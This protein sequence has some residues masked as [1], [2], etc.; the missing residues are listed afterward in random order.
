MLLNHPNSES[1]MHSR[2]G[3]FCFLIKVWLIDFIKALTH[4][5]AVLTVSIN[6]FKT[7]VPRMYLTILIN[8]KNPRGN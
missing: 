6:T 5:S 2:H 7:D 3:T 8:T 1:C 4:V